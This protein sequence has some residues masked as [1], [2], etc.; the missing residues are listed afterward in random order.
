MPEI[1]IARRD[2]NSKQLDERFAFRE[3]IDRTIF[4]INDFQVVD[5]HRVIDRLGDVRGRDGLVG[6]VFRKPIT[7]PVSLTTSNATTDQDIGQTMRPVISSCSHFSTGTNITNLGG[8]AHFARD[9]Q[10][11]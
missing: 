10:R 2:K 4:S 9:E 7:R 11:G 5:A 1:L 6:R 8:S 3:Q